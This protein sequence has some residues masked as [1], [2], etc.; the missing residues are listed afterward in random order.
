MPFLFLKKHFLKNTYWSGK[1]CLEFFV[2]FLGTFPH[3]KF[4]LFFFLTNSLL[5]S[6]IGT[7]M[8][9]A[10]K[11]LTDLNMQLGIL[12]VFPFGISC[13][14]VAP[15]CRG[16]TWRSEKW[17][18]ETSTHMSQALPS[19]TLQGLRWA[20]CSPQPKY[21]ELKLESSDCMFLASAE[22]G[23]GGGIDCLCSTPSHHQNPGDEKS[24]LIGNRLEQAKILSRECFACNHC[25]SHLCFSARL[26][27]YG[28]KR[29][30]L[31]AQLQN[32]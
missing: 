24:V 21:M 32:K 31:Q 30:V 28:K 12:S 26:G 20:V 16:K 4:V 7:F 1:M 15:T 8:S 17:P 13:W 23:E 5:A 22:P 25:L 18:K 2:K 9:T 3:R 19:I 27:I 6:L 11:A 10:P 14:A 29:Q